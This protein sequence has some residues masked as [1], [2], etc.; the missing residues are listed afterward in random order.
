[1]AK[2]ARARSKHQ[3]T[4]W[5][6]VLLEEHEIYAVKIM[7][8]QHPKGFEVLVEK[9]ANADAMSFSPG[10]ADVTAFAEG[11]RWV[12]RTARQIVGL[13][14]PGPPREQGDVAPPANTVEANKT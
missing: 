5:D 14:M 9:I 8:A 13:K 12:G 7:A 6:D 4:P 11:K 1:M 3:R 2:A 10:A